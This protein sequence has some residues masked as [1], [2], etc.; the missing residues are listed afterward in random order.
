MGVLL[1]LFALMCYKG[2][3]SPKWK[4]HFKILIMC[5]LV[6]LISRSPVDIVQFKELIN[7]A[8]GFKNLSVRS[9]ELEWE[10]ML[11]V[12]HPII[13]MAFVS[14]YRLGALKT[15]RTICGCQQKYE[16]KQQE[17]MDHYKS[18]E[19]LSERSAVS[20]TQVSN[21]L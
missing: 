5:T 2:T 16:Q 18:D 14:E 6:F 11:I 9:F 19:I 10:I 13:I 15:L 7:A 12:L 3:K 17:K 20:K 4:R 21:M 8:R 1:L